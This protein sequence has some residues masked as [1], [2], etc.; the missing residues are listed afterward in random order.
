MPA[1]HPRSSSFLIYCY[2]SMHSTTCSIK[3]DI[4]R[5]LILIGFVIFQCR[6]SQNIWEQSLFVIAYFVEHRYNISWWTCQLMVIFARWAIQWWTKIGDLPLTNETLCSI[7]ANIPIRQKST[8]MQPNG[9]LIE[10][11][12]VHPCS[13]GTLDEVADRQ[14]CPLCRLVLGLTF[15]DK[16][17][18]SAVR[19]DQSPCILEP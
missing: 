17:L 18:Q 5:I 19:W 16:T 1:C 8:L 7:C 12:L 13:L 2:L 6:R 4:F 15:K 10:M 9:V 14:N 11:G 3:M